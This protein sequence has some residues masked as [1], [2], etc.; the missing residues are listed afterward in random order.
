MAAGRPR[1]DA[2]RRVAISC[3]DPHLP[4]ARPIASLRGSGSRGCP[5]G[6]S[7]YDVEIVRGKRALTAD[8]ALRL[9]RDFGT[10]P[11]FWHNL[12][13]QHDLDVEADRLGDR[14]DR[15]VAARAR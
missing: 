12:Q 5:N 4:T 3:D 11:R 6:A 13:A 1:R 7:C 8:T 2:T 15:E 9:A 10:T 14:L